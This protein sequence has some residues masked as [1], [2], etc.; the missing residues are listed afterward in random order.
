M[1]PSQVCSGIA[2]F[3]HLGTVKL[4]RYQEDSLIGD[5]IPRM[6][7]YVA[8]KDYQTNKKLTK[9]ETNTKKRNELK[10]KHNR[11]AH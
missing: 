10:T 3:G 6:Y 11:T 8:R 2:E 9:K 5:K 7:K 4:G 1:L